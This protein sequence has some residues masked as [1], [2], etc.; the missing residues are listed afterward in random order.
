M[1]AGEGIGVRTRRGRK[2]REWAGEGGRGLQI[3]SGV[4]PAQNQ[5]VAQRL[6][7]KMSGWRHAGQVFYCHDVLVAVGVP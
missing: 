3:E 7:I 5:F 2:V 6:K 1:P 4:G